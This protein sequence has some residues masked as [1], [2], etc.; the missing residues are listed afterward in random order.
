MELL[1]K[2][3]LVALYIAFLPITL[4]I[5]ILYFIFNKVFETGFIANKKIDEYKEKKSIDENNCR[6]KTIKFF[7]DPNNPEKIVEMFIF[8]NGKVKDDNFIY[9]VNFYDINKQF[10]ETVEVEYKKGY[11]SEY[12]YEIRG[13][14]YYHSEF[15]RPERHDFKYF[16]IESSKDFLNVDIKPVGY[17]VDDYKSNMGKKFK[18]SRAFYTEYKP[19]KYEN[20]E[21]DLKYTYYEKK[22]SIFFE[23]NE[24]LLEGSYPKYKC[25]LYDKNNKLLKV[26]EE[27]LMPIK[28]INKLSC[29]FNVEN[30]DF[31]YYKIYSDISDLPELELKPKSYRIIQEEQYYKNDIYIEANRYIRFEINSIIQNIPEGEYPVYRCN[32]FDKNKQL[33]KTIHQVPMDTYLSSIRRDYFLLALFFDTEAI[34]FSY[35]SIYCDDETFPRTNVLSKEYY[36]KK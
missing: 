33:I 14:N 31:D 18:I 8:V 1:T 16:S 21:F 34:E 29:E 28:Y 17:Y 5:T 36:I 2:I 9:N 3:I 27:K 26:I 4:P 15:I 10:I 35:F 7:C 23:I 30:V 6:I 13:T 25:E 22:N 12:D 11:S 32:L 20:K 24:G 19:C